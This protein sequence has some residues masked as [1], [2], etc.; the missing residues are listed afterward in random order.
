[1]AEPSS[2]PAMACRNVASTSSWSTPPIDQ[3]PVLSRDPGIVGDQVDGTPYNFTA[4]DQAPLFFQDHS[5]VPTQLDQAPLFFQDPSGVPTQLDPAW[6][7]MTSCEQA[8]TYD[9]SY[10]GGTAQLQLE[11]QPSVALAQVSMFSQVSTGVAGHNSPTGYQHPF[12]SDKVPGHNATCFPDSGV[13]PTEQDGMCYSTATSAQAPMFSQA[14][15]GFRGHVQ[16]SA[17]N[18]NSD[19]AVEQ[20][21]AISYLEVSSRGAA[22]ST[23]MLTA[24]GQLNHAGYLEPG[25]GHSST[26]LQN[27][28]GVSS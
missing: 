26:F 28:V 3:A 7:S 19:G 21:N 6:L 5:G 13:V 25:A 1:M 20:F 27:P 11:P 14:P 4:L 2:R 23:Y 16:R 17:Y 8:P 15:G 12:T 18:Q 9:Q 22:P 10:G 24:S